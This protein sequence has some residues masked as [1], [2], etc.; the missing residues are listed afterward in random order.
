MRGAYSSKR[1][2]LFDL[3]GTLVDSVPAHARAF[4]EALRPVH[5]EL[6]ESFEYAPFA[7]QPTRQIFWTLG[8]QEPELSE[9]TRRKQELYREALDR[10][11]VRPFPGAETLLARLRGEN[12]RVF[13]VTGAS[14]ISAERVLETSKLGRWT[15][16]MIAAEDTPA[17]KPAPAPYLLALEKFGLAAGDCLVIEDG[18]SGVAAAQ[19]AG[20]DVV[21]INADLQLEGVRH[22]G[23]CGQFL[24]L[25]TGGV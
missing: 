20:I 2:F 1:N 21:L 23:D 24:A 12:K 11:E 18:E 17:G 19:A 15:D 22:V 5:A 7:G 6:A 3:D 4:A 8:M 10:G 16:G 9:L 13:I 25:L 14:R